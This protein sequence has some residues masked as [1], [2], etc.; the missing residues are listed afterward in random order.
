LTGFIPEALRLTGRFS[1]GKPGLWP[2]VA[3]CLFL[4]GTVRAETLWESAARAYQAGKFEEAKGD[5]LQLLSQGASSPALFYNLGNTWWQLGQKGRAI[6]NYRRALALEPHADDAQANLRH[7]LNQTGQDPPSP[8]R[9]ELS[10]YADVYPVVAAATFWTM[11]FALAVGLTSRGGALLRVTTAL[12]WGSGLLCLLSL[13]LCWFVGYGEK[14]PHGAI[15]L[16]TSLDL[17][18]GPAFSTRIAETVGEGQEVT[19]LQERGAWILC[20][21]QTGLAGWVP[22]NALERIVPR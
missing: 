18:V 4:S 11:A 3:V 13:G 14:D 7:A 20:R 22:S 17:K 12:A 15:V 19:I 10:F 2:F 6:L 5:Y 9:T 8:F 1:R 21:S 16:P